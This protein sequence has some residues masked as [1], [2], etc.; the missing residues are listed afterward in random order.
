MLSL[1]KT[2]FIIGIFFAI[3]NW[4]DKIDKKLGSIE[5]TLEKMEK[6]TKILDVI[7]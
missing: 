3:I 2:I 7:P 1:I 5:Q 6:R 4:S